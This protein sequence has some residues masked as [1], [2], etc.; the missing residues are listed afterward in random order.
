MVIIGLGN[1]LPQLGHNKPQI[2]ILRPERITT[3][4]KFCHG[5]VLVLDSSVVRAPARKA[6]YPGLS[7][8]AVIEN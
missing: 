2:V 5:S 7:Q 8:Q 4:Q 6:G 3:R 1:T